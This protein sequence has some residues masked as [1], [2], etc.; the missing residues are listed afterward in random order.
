MLQFPTPVSASTTRTRAAA[1]G[2][3]ALWCLLSPMTNFTRLLEAGQ[4]HQHCSSEQPGPSLAQRAQCVRT[5][6]L[7]HPCP[8]RGARQDSRTFGTE[9]SHTRAA[10][11]TPQR[12][13]ASGAPLPPGS[14][15]QAG[16]LPRER[17]MSCFLT[18]PS[19]SSPGDSVVTHTSLPAH[20]LSCQTSSISPVNQTSIRNLRICWKNSPTWVALWLIT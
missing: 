20:S 10:P 7:C 19:H 16:T 9:I 4:L 14:P 6:H 1:V 8:A 3:R 15:R 5:W 18:A 11:A 13:S 12:A 17:R 2:R